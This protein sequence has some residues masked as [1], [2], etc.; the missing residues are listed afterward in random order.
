MLAKSVKA[1]QS[2]DLSDLKRQSA[3]HEIFEYELANGLLKLHELVKKIEEFPPEA[4]TPLEGRVELCLA[5]G[6]L[7]VI[8]PNLFERNA[9]PTFLK[10]LRNKITQV[11]DEDLVEKFLKVYFY[12]ETELYILAAVRY[13]FFNDMGEEE[14]DEDE[15]CLRFMKASERILNPL[16]KT[17]VA[18]GNSKDSL[19][20]QR[21]LR[22]Q[23]VLGIFEG[24]V[25]FDDRFEAFMEALD[26]D[27]V[28]MSAFQ[29][30]MEVQKALFGMPKFA[31]TSSKLV[32]IASS[33]TNGMKETATATERAPSS[34]GV[35]V[36]QVS[37]PEQP[38]KRVRLEPVGSS[39]TALK[40]MGP[41]SLPMLRAQAPQK[42]VVSNN[43][44]DLGETQPDSPDEVESP[45]S[46]ASSTSNILGGSGAPGRARFTDEEDEA[47]RAGVRKHGEGRWKAI[48]EDPAFAT[49]FKS[50]KPRTAVNLKDRWRNIV[51]KRVM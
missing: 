30:T 8:K 44:R 33:A 48:L 6:N 7:C 39:T 13:Y 4:G 17:K 42:S 32:T 11:E 5:Y 40:P 2:L 12:L 3:R 15:R 47:L 26:E 24:G 27:S 14:S 51:H 9:L 28:I 29:L 49:V 45:V 37:E 22:L 38:L 1:I 23:D 20:L 34:T 50:V 19:T 18:A 35:R 16:M 31:P 25:I 36:A 43:R 10:E 46:M 21:N 41:P